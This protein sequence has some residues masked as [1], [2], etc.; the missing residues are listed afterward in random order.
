MNIRIK[1]KKYIIYSIQ[2]KN[3]KYTEDNYKQPRRIK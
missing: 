2:K 3:V 1:A